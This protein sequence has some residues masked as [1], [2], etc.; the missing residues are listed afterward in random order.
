MARKPIP[1]P[2]C[3]GVP[4]FDKS[5]GYVKVDVKG[6]KH[7]LHR[8]L[9]EEVNGPIAEGMQIDHINGDRADNRL[10]NL[11]LATPTQ[12]SA[13]KLVGERTHIEVRGNS[14]MVRFFAMGVRYNFGSYDSLELA[15]LVRDEA[16][17]KYL[18]EWCGRWQES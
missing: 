14:H 18:G 13:N 1:R 15:Q 4:Y 10:D 6:K 5:N 7:Y 16:L 12:N 8:L 3:G 2:R 17:T 9:W 11:R